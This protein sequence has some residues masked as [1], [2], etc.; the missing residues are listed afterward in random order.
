MVANII[1]AFPR[2]DDAKNVKNILVRS[3]F[4][5]SAICTTGA[6][7][8][9]YADGL[10]TGIIIS[11]YKLADI[12]FFEIQECMPPG[13]ELLV[14]ASKQRLAECEGRGAVTLPMPFVISDFLDT[15]QMMVVAAERRRKQA[16]MVPRKR[17]DDDKA[18]INSAKE[19]LMDRNGLTED[20]AHKF[21]QKCSMDSGINL[22]ESAQMVLSMF[23]RQAEKIN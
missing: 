4:S 20:E 11:S 23:D 5:V 18:I 22:I 17:S 2:L 6:Q 19:L 3:G 13:F 7:A 9:S 10:G 16:R 8:L 14:L 21:I 15:V 1:V 12:P